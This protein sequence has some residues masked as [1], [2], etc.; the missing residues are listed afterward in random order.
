MKY[1]GGWCYANSLLAAVREIADKI[2]DGDIEITDVCHSYGIFIEQMSE[3]ERE[4]FFRMVE[5]YVN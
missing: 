2:G 3:S 4:E 5:S 1:N